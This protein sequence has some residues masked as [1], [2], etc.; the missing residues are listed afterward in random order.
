MSGSVPLGLGMS[1][2]AN[3]RTLAV[4]T[5]L[6]VK[7]GVPGSFGAFGSADPIA[8]TQTGQDLSVP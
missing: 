8:V 7:V 3:R 6:S 1:P 5:S 4:S 2:Q